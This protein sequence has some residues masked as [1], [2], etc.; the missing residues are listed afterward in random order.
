MT[1]YTINQDQYDKLTDIQK[2]YPELT[3]Q[4]HG[5]DTLIREALQIDALNAL[6]EAEA[7][8]KKHIKGCVSFNHF[9]L[10]KQKE[11]ELR[12]Q[13]HYSDSFTGVGYLKLS[14]LLNG[15]EK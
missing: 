15:F 10:N 6:K 11:I 5:Y 9:K 7:I 1:I 12:V 4:N 2:T 14:E 8:I 13:Y 3:Y